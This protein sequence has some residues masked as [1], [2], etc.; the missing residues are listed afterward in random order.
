[1]KYFL[2]ALAFAAGMAAAAD[3]NNGAAPKTKKS[4]AKPLVIEDQG[5][6][7]IGGVP[8]V[9]YYASA[10][11]P[12]NPSAAPAPPSRCSKTPRGGTP[13]ASRCL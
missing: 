7:F 4:L 11:T 13:K 1:M 6:F 10:P 2:T 8:K 3:V 9:T 5:S 12:N